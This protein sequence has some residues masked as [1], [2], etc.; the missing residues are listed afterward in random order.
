MAVTRPLG[1]LLL[2]LVIASGGKDGP[3]GALSF[4]SEDLVMILIG[5]ALLIIG[6]VMGEA[7]R[8]A[9]DNAGFV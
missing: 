7:A 8:I 6:R 2:S 5:S 4:S 1:W 9:D 3:H